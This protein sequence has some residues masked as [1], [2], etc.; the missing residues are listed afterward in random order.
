MDIIVR[1]G[2]HCAPWISLCAVGIIVRVDIIVRRGYHAVN[3]ALVFSKRAIGPTSSFPVSL[4]TI[5]SIQ[6]TPAP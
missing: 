2:Y 1:R 5:P 6:Y 4:E 3:S